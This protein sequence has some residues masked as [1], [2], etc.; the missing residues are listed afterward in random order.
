MHDLGFKQNQVKALSCQVSV[1]RH[2]TYILMTL[3]NKRFSR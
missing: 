2:T 3:R 1:A